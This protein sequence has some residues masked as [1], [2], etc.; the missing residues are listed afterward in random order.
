MRTW[1][2]LSAV[3]WC[4]TGGGAPSARCPVLSL[5]PSFPVLPPSPCPALPCPTLNLSPLLSKSQW[6]LSSAVRC[7]R[8][9]LFNTKGFIYGKTGQPGNKDLYTRGPIGGA[10]T[11]KLFPEELPLPGG[12]G[13]EPAFIEH[14][15]Y[16]ASAWQFTTVA[17]FHPYSDPYC[18]ALL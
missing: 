16:Q 8:S 1:L 12:K 4:L 18:V 13:N 14:L 11:A 9:T 3:L 2:L 10:G 7:P 6:F 15:L 17:S 5:C